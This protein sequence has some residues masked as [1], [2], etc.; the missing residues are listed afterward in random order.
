MKNQDSYLFFTFSA[1]H[2]ILTGFFIFYIP[3]LLWSEFHS[4]S[5]ICYFIS[6]AGLSYAIILGIF[7]I[8]LPKILLKTLIQVS[9]WIPVVFLL[10]FLLLFDSHTLFLGILYGAYACFY[11]MLHRFLFFEVSKKKSAGKMF[12]NFQILVFVFLKISMFIAAFLLEKEQFIFILLLSIIVIFYGHLTFSKQ[13][14]S[15]EKLELL[16]KYQAVSVQDIKDFFHHP[17]FSMFLIDGVFLYLESFFWIITLYTIAGSSLSKVALLIIFLSLVFGAIHWKLKNTLDHIPY[18]KLFLFLVCLYSFSWILRGIILSITSHSLIAI[19]LI[20]ITF[21]TL[22]FRLTLNKRF[23]DNARCQKAYSYMVIKSYITQ[24]SLSLFF[25]LLGLVS[26]LFMGDMA[27]FN[28]FYIG[29]SLLAL[30]YLR[31]PGYELKE[32]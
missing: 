19:V 23:Y 25:L 2:S 3:L 24:I 5:L 16:Q 7:E 21:S 30:F 1:V 32:D 10:G 8:L 4:F 26:V 31:Y 11:Y 13:R 17:S 20:V 27:T 29:A 6:I 12:G 9:F 18:Q 28:I 15:F 22:L 14:F